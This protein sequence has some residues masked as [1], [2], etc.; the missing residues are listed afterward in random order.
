MTDTKPW[1]MSRTVW[2]GLA[3]S[4]VALLSAMGWLPPGITETV[5][6]EAVVAILGVLTVI[7]RTKA[8]KEIEPVIAQQ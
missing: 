5:V 7:F 6:E 3:T 8:V 4:I 2:V 1:W